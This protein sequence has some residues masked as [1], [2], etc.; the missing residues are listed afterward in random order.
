MYAELSCSLI[1]HK[2]ISG[3]E[4]EA[5]ENEEY[6]G[7]CGDADGV[8]LCCL[9]APEEERHQEQLC[10]TSNE[11]GEGKGIASNFSLSMLLRTRVNSH[12]VM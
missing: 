5:W 8:Y 11:P 7:P 9:E 4:I 2:A 6:D 3:D 1:H 10:Y 12:F